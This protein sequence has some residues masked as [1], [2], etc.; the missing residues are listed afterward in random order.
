MI[1]YN[2][3]SPTYIIN[4][5]KFPASSVPPLTQL[6][7]SFVFPAPLE[8]IAIVNAS[9]FERDTNGHFWILK[10]TLILLAKYTVSVLAKFKTCDWL[11]SYILVSKRMKWSGENNN[12]TIQEHLLLLHFRECQLNYLKF[13]NFVVLYRV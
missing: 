4:H 7:N 9:E 3:I 10:A 11:N 8:P 2:A 12:Q 1:G 5:L 13:H 6:L